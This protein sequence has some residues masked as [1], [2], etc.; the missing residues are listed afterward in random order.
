MIPML[1]SGPK[2]PTDGFTLSSSLLVTVYC[3]ALFVGGILM[4]RYRPSLPSRLTL[5][6]I[7]L[8]AIL[9][10]VNDAI[11]ML[12]AI[13]I[14][15]AVSHRRWSFFERP[16]V[17][18]LGRISYPLYLVQTTVFLAIGLFSDNLIAALLVVPASLAVAVV[19]HRFVE[20]P[21]I[22]LCSAITKRRRPVAVRT[23]RPAVQVT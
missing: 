19:L 2:R 11:L 5:P 3:V 1:L 17:V 16:S 6:S 13:G 18:W 20:V 15:A 14:V 7:A 8:C 4:A 12:A 23:T 9:G 10:Y 21:S 22:Q